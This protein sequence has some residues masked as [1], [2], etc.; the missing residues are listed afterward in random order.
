MGLFSKKKTFVGASTVSLIEDTPDIV[1]ASVSTAIL[2]G[3]DIA[4]DIVG[5]YLNGIYVN[6]NRY[7]SYARDSYYY[8][9][10]DGSQET[11][12]TQD[13]IIQPIIEKEVGFPITLVSNM[14][15]KCDGD[16]LAYPW[17]TENRGWDYKTNLCSTHSL[18][19]DDGSG[20]QVP[21]TAPLY[22]D[23]AE[24]TGTNQLTIQYTYND[25]VSKYVR[26]VVSLTNVYP[27]EYY[28]HVIYVERGKTEPRYYWNYRVNNGT[29]PELNVNPAIDLESPYYPVVPIREHNKDLTEDKDSELYK[30]SKY[31]LNIIGL[32]ITELAEGINENPDV[33]DIDHAYVIMGIDILSEKSQSIRYLH[34]Y[35]D[36]LN[37]LNPYTLSRYKNYLLNRDSYDDTNPP[38]VEVITIKDANYHIELAYSYITSE[39]KTGTIGSINECTRTDKV[40][41]AH[42][43]EGY[44]A[45]QSSVIFRRQ[46]TETTYSEVEVFGLTHVNYIYGN[47]SVNTALGDAYAVDSQGDRTNMNFVVPLNYAV[48]RSMGIF[49]ANELMYDAIKMV[50]NSV[51][52]VKLKWYQT[53]FFKFVLI[54]VAIAITIITY[55]PGALTQSLLGGAVAVG[56]AT[57]PTVLTDIILA[58]VIKEAFTMVVEVVGAE[59]AFAVAIILACYGVSSAMGTGSVQG[60]PFASEALMVANNLTEAATSVGYEELA[61]EQAA[62]EL[63]SEAMTAELVE[64]I[65]ELESKHELDP[66]DIFTDFGNDYYF[67]TPTDYIYTSVHAGNIGV[68]TLDGPRNFVEI[69]LS[70][71]SLSN[72]LGVDINV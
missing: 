71:P 65:E 8:G 56:T 5:N 24:P 47:Y 35:F 9:L 28:H 62:F 55:Q 60:L 19:E 49:K 21:I 63:E 58:F 17:L 4:P 67:Q 37:D 26:E 59:L 18:T 25:G 10:P 45:D 51:E 36:Y 38:P 30:T 43:G 70:L 54:I 16:S 2:K 42:V 33:S 32:D 1:G 69:T 7:Y 72:S 44:S 22:F 57:L 13:Y 15:D 27:G 39:I 66:L 3:R 53:Q 29:Y 40:E 64:N 23:G 52:T 41:P 20:T 48:V 31:L 34:D 46:L 50:F 11:I 61:I 68:T 14:L 6:S 12:K